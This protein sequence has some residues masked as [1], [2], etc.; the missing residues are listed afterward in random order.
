MNSWL[1]KVFGVNVAELVVSEP[2]V[3][4]RIDNTGGSFE[5]D[6]EAYSLEDEEEWASPDD[7]IYKSGFGF[8]GWR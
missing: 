3:V 7:P 6:T 4:V 8:G 2:E 1:L 5:V